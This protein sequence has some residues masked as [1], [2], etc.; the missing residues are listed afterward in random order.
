M[1]KRIYVTHMAL[2]LYMLSSLSVMGQMGQ[3]GQGRQLQLIN[4]DGSA[5][6]DSVAVGVIAP[7]VYLNEQL[8]MPSV[9]ANGNV[10]IPSDDRQLVPLTADERGIHSIPADAK[11]VV[12]QNQHGFA[13]VP[14]G[15]LTGKAKL[16][17]WAKLKID[18]ATVPEQVRSKYQLHVLW[19]N[20]F[21]G[22]I[23]SGVLQNMRPGEDPFGGSPRVDP[24]GSPPATLP[25]W[26]FH[27]YATLFQQADIVDQTIA[28][29]PGEV[30]IV[31]TGLSSDLGFE[32]D[33][34]PSMLSVTLGIVRTVSN[35]TADFALPTFGSAQGRL[36]GNVNLPNWG[37]ASDQ[38]TR[39]IATP[40]RAADVP[41]PRDLGH[42]LAGMAGSQDSRSDPFAA[43]SVAQH[44]KIADIYAR[45][46]ASVEGTIMRTSGIGIAVAATDEQ[47]EFTFDALPI[48]EY[49]LR[50]MSM[51]T[52]Q[53]I[54]TDYESAQG[55][56]AVES[57]SPDGL[58][59]VIKANELTELGEVRWRV[60][61]RAEEAVKSNRGEGDKL[62]DSRLPSLPAARSNPVSPD[63]FAVAAQSRIEAALNKP[64]ENIDFIGM[65]LAQVME[66]L[67]DDM[68]IP[69]V[70]NLKKLEMRGVSMDAPITMN[71][72]PVTLRSVLNLVLDQVA[73]GE[74]TFVARDEVL[75]IT[76]REDA[77]KNPGTSSSEASEMSKSLAAGTA[78]ATDDRATEIIERW[79]KSTPQDADRSELK[80]LLENHLA[81][82][83][84]TNQKTRRAE[85]DRLQQLL[86]QSRTW[87]DQR[88][89][90]REAIIQGRVQELLK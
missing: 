82:E 14:P 79:L 23:P 21:A 84:D 44:D 13:F 60:D 26:R 38:A 83:F 54:P 32:S 35:Q 29:P 61:Q 68:N 17:P 28:V 9:D 55:L 56:T 48:G 57:D 75:L 24:F 81:A 76:T 20:D 40:V 69:I 77:A 53:E 71:L 31:L 90:Q 49:E 80:Q 46:F 5:A 85:I 47:G 1:R 50:M 89:Q 66:I 52:M 27:N 41:P 34:S 15:A 3:L 63:Q 18:T 10:S 33:A 43:P 19:R 25:D 88:Q 87:L 45:H 78:P 12:A 62:N 37:R 67:S 39:I 11:A 7:G 73:S 4:P 8:A 42:L 59:F 22:H 36:V 30:T 70:F 58:R 65:P 64:V 72:P 2:T 16:R 74:L 86:E 51:D 6:A